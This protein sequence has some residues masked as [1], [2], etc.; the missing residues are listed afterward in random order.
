MTKYYSF[1]EAVEIMKSGQVM[2]GGDE[3][4]YYFMID[5]Q[6]YGGSSADPDHHELDLERERQRKFYVIDGMTNECY[7]EWIKEGFSE[8]VKRE[9]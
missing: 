9:D 2:G 5:G 3:C 1:D 8:F 6:V 4:D 7:I